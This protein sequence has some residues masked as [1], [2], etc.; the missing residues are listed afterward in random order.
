MNAL[1][2]ILGIL[3]AILGLIMLVI[4]IAKFSTLYT[5]SSKRQNPEHSFMK[6]YL[7]MMASGFMV[8]LPVLVKAKSP[9]EEQVF[10]KIRRQTKILYW[11]L[12]LFVVSLIIQVAT[13]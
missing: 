4:L 10:L 12:L 7:I 2:V 3:E 1:T 13:A 9:E 6:N 5:Y 11:S 8:W